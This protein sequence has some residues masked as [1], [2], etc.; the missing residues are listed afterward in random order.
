M[1]IRDLKLFYHLAET[2]RFSRTAQEMHV[3]PST[4]S[5]QIQR[6][7]ET[8]GQPL[9]VRDNRTVELT[10]AGEH[11]KLFAQ[12]TLHQYQQ[13][14]YTLGQDGAALN[15]ELHLFCSVTAAYSHLPPILDRFRAK[16]PMVEIKLITGDAADTLDKIQKNEA[17][18][19]IAGKPDN[20][21]SSINFTKI[22]EIPLML[23]APSLPGA[24]HTQV[25]T[26]HPDW[27]SIP[28]ILPEHGPSR[29]RIEQWFNYHHISNPM[30]YASVSGHEAIVP[31]VALGCGI[32]L[33]PS[34]V[35][36]NCPNPIRDR[37][38]ELD[39]VSMI[40]PLEL[41]LCVQKKNLNDPLIHAFWKTLSSL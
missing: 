5:R 24:V 34:V 15:G 23:I 11:L 30:I 26:K 20:L 31:M 36:E 8:L 40:K 12:Q 14:K 1:D 32:A 28:F 13:L 16:H 22:D 37:I 6:L 41:G 17:D 29:K 10:D 35:V 9:F 38:I 33:I 21:P 18:I 4:L 19:G 39:H 2:R 7:E 25:S 3:T 27:S